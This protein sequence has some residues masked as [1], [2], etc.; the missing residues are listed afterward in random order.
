MEGRTTCFIVSSVFAVDASVNNL[1]VSVNNLS[2]LE[3]DD[4][5]HWISRIAIRYVSSTTCMWTRSGAA[6]PLLSSVRSSGSVSAAIL[7]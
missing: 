7:W 6:N 2:L 1:D 5:L 4:S 3:E